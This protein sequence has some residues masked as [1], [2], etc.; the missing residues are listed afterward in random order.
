MNL[1]LYFIYAILLIGIE[2]GTT[3]CEDKATFRRLG[4]TLTIL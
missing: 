4:E 2:D 3:L 1:K